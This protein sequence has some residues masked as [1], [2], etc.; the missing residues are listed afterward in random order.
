MAVETLDDGIVSVGE[1]SDASAST[2]CQAGLS[3]RA[4]L[5]ECKVLLRAAAPACAARNQLEFYD[6][7]RAEGHGYF[8]VQA[9]RRIRHEDGSAFFQG[10][11]DFG[12]AHDLGKMRGAD[13]FFAF[14]DK[15]KIYGHLL[16]R[17]AHGVQCGEERGLGAFLVD[18]AT[19]DNDFAEAGLID[20]RGVEWRRAPL[21]G[22]RLLYVVHEIETDRAR[23]AGV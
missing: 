3:T 21:R 16:S 12:F 8:A 6:A 2:R 1:T 15:N 19:A 11:G 9:L 17:A 14:G 13:F 7:F 4:L 23:R 5:L 20:Q 22:I 10:S 18:G